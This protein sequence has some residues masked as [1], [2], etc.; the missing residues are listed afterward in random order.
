M[1]SGMFYQSN[2]SLDQ[3]ERNSMTGDLFILSPRHPFLQLVID[4]VEKTYTSD[5][6]VWGGIGPLLLTTCLRNFTEVIMDLYSARQT[7]K[8]LSNL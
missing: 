5:P 8:S 2:S 4:N 7:E 3:C 1:A 6:S